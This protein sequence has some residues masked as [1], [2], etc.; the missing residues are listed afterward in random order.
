MKKN[1]KS[2]EN[3]SNNSK[4]KISDIKSYSKSSSNKEV[5]ITKTDDDMNSNDI[6]DC[7]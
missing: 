5:D 6:N 1:K 2:T 4:N 3:I 7:R